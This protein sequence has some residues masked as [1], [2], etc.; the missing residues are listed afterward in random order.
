MYILQ[1]VG[2]TFAG[3]DRVQK[4]QESTWGASDEKGH[5]DHEEIEHMEIVCLFGAKHHIALCSQQNLIF[6]TLICV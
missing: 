5:R 2:E 3:Q 6:W 1:L 4:W